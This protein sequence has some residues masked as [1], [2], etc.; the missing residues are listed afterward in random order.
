[1][2]YSVMTQPPAGTNLSLRGL[3]YLTLPD[4]FNG[5]TGLTDT[6]NNSSLLVSGGLVTSLNWSFQ[7]GDFY[8]FFTPTGFQTQNMSSGG[9]TNTFGTLAFSPPEQQTGP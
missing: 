9:S 1:T 6:P 5:L 4:T 8:A 7:M 2:F 3:I